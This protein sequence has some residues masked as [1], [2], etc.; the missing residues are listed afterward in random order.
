[1]NCAYY[2]RQLDGLLKVNGLKMPEELRRHVDSCPECAAHKS[3]LLALGKI[4]GETT[5]TIELGEL[6]HINFDN[7]KALALGTK[8]KPAKTRRGFSFKWL[9]APAAVAMA[10]AAFLIFS[11]KNNNSIKNYSD[12]NIDISLTSQDLENQISSSDSLS[13]QLLSSLATNDGEFDNAADELTNNANLDDLINGLTDNEL[14]AFYSKI[15][16]LK[17]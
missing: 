10:V 17:G 9:W 11:P 16:D 13:K 12:I 14:D 5:Y 8:D 1:M 2:Q 6:D 4:I 3:E 7:I 15:N